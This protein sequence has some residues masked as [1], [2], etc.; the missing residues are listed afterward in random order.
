MPKRDF[1]S[2]TSAERAELAAQ[3]KRVRLERGFTQAELAHEAGVT[4]QSI[5]NL[6]GGRITPQSSTIERV[7]AVLGIDPNPA[8]FSEDT[9]RWLGIIGGI[10]DALPPSRRARAG[11]AA[12]NAVTAELVAASN[13]G[14]ERETSLPARQSDFDLVAHPY[15]DETGELMDE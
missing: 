4:R 8:E 9:S 15:T 1:V 6:E 3:V 7:L 10:I 2:L 13:V 12:V 11:Q 5:G 14:G